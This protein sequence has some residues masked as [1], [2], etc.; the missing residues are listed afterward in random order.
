MAWVVGD[1][2]RETGT[3]G[4]VCK[5]IEVHCAATCGSLTLVLLVRQLLFAPVLKIAR[6]LAIPGV[7]LTGYMHSSR[8][9]HTNAGYYLET[10]HFSCT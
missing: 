4:L 7:P 5:W 2:I 3:V 1:K 9:V 10:F 6:H 8:G